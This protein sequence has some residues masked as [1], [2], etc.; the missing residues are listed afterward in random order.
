VTKDGKCLFCLF[1][2]FIYFFSLSESK[3][4]VGS[5]ITEELVVSEK[6]KRGYPAD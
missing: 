6:E 2:L 3:K 4:K 1:Y 5:E